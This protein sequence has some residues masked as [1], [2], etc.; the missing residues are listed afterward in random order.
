MEISEKTKSRLEK[1]GS[2]GASYDAVIN[3]CIDKLEKID[4]LVYLCSGDDTDCRQLYDGLD[5]M[6]FVA[7]AAKHDGVM[8][9]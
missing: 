5:D 6:F 2:V 7:F 3:E 1:I 9:R 4:R 8:T